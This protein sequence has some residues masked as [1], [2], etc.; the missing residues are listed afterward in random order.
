[1]ATGDRPGA[2][3]IDIRPWWPANGRSESRA[4]LQESRKAANFRLVIFKISI[5][6]RDVFAWPARNGF[7]SSWIYYVLRY[8]KAY[9]TFSVTAFRWVAEIA[10]DQGR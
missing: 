3:C 10:M 7:A 8:W 2:G 4:S 5:Q 1:M 6:P 9:L